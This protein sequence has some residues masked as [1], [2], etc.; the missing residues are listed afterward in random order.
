[1]TTRAQIAA[2]ARTWL[3]T[4]WQHQ[5]RLKGV[6]TDCIGLVAGVAHALRL[7]GS[8]EWMVDQ[9]FR[10]YGRT[11]D[12]ELLLAGCA[13]FM[14]PIPVA[15]ATLGDVLVMRAANVEQPTHF[16]I[17]SGVDPTY[18]IH[19]RLA[20]KVSEN[21]LDATLAALVLYAFRFRGVA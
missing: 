16:A 19:S 11:P 13:E 4:R 18:I 3:G 5:A 9:R 14:D 10:S 15:A 6:A 2:E 21:R 20:R 12:P 7:P 1:L 17:V 8:D